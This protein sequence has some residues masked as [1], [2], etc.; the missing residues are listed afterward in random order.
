MMAFM[1]TSKPDKNL[2][3]NCF[4]IRAMQT[5]DLPYVMNLECQVF[6]DP[7]TSEMFLQDIKKYDAKVLLNRGQEIIG[8]LCGWQ[9]QDEYSLN[10]FAI[11]PDWKNRGLGRYLLEKLLSELKGKEIKFVYLEVRHSNTP[12]LGLYKSVGFE[13]IATRKNYYT[14]PREDAYIM[15]LLL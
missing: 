4:S 15:R 8:Y 1:L 2:D 14:K 9:Q 11:A 10:N 3:T 6:S 7:W 12:A 5:E 13:I